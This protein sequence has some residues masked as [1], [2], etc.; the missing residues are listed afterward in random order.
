MQIVEP[1]EEMERA[2]ATLGFE[3]FRRGQREAIEQVF[4]HGKALLVAPTGGGKSLTYQLP[5]VML[6]GTTLVV[7]PLIS[8]ME[9][10]VSALE[11]R[12]IPCTYLASTL[13]SDELRCRM[14]KAREG[15]YRLLYVAPERLSFPGFRGML[16]EMGCPL[17]AIDEAH[18]IS[19]WGHDFRPDY[20]QI[21]DFLRSM[22][23]NPRVLACTATATPVVR[24]E[25]VAKLGL[26]ADTPQLIHGFA[27]PNLALRAVEV[28]GVRETRTHVDGV[29]AETLG[30][31][32]GRML[33]GAGAAIIYAPTRRKADSEGERLASLGWKAAVYHAGLSASRRAKVSE[34]FAAG[35]LEVVVATN[36]F[37]MGIDRPDVRAVVHLGP[38]GSIEAY[39]QEVGRAG[40]DG[41]PAVGMLMTST[42]DFPLR[43]RLLELE[44][45]G[46]APDPE[47]VEHK[48]NTF[49]ELMR[50]ADSGTCRHDGILRYFGDEAEVLDGCGRCDVCEGRVATADLSEEEVVLVVRKILSAVAR[51][52][53]RLGLGAAVRLAKGSEDPRLRRYRLDEVRTFGALSEFPEPWLTRVARRCVSA[54]WVSFTSG[55][56]P[57]VLLTQDGDAVM[58]GNVAPKISLPPVRSTSGRAARS[59][60]RSRTPSAEDAT[61]DAEASALFEALRVHRLEVSREH[62][63]PPY[64]VASDRT[65]REV[66]VLRPGDMDAL[67]EVHGIGPS[68]AARFGE[69]LLEVVARAEA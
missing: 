69:G 24:D 9:D 42:Q 27:R 58:R 51:C 34:R 17:V 40:R 54:G 68:K 35:K 10:Q 33:R 3:T 66:A 49:L 43:R 19:E 52:H 60:T 23:G 18:C 25:I 11:K 14:R 6:E 29:L 7:C 53:D 8:L 45:D 38:P 5:A 55:D 39:Y 48:W 62:S 28:G 61:L 21:G 16:A 22:P 13:D 57:V 50:W 26:G 46:R 41:E 56:H 4:A 47:M 64:V 44:V 30:E 15:D 20:L 32:A 2:L 59:S 31:P 1:A 36:A 63:V 67:L 65:L 37:G 12:G